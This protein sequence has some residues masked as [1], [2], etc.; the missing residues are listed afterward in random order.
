MQNAAADKRS[1]NDVPQLLQRPAVERLIRD[2]HVVIDRGG[3]KLHLMLGPGLILR[4]N[5]DME[6]FFQR[7]DREND[8]D[9][10]D[11]VRACVPDRDIGVVPHRVERFLRRA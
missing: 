10:R 1:V 3:G 11:G 4:R 9:D 7:E 2:R 6:R 5:I 8:R